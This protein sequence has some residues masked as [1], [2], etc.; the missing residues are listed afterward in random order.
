MKRAIFFGLCLLNIFLDAGLA[1]KGIWRTHARASE[2]TTVQ[3]VVAPEKIPLSK[4]VQDDD[5]APIPPPT[6]YATVYSI[7]PADFA[8]NLRR[9]GCPEETVKDILFAEI[10]RRYHAR[11]KQLRPKPADHV[12]FMWSPKT[13]EA[14]LIE[15]RQEAAEIAREKADA[16]R[17][18]L[19]YDVTV[20]MPLY[21]MTVSDQ[22]FQEELDA[23]PEKNRQAAHAAQEQY[24][25]M[26][27]QL[28]SRTHGFW[29]PEDVQELNQLKQQRREML[30]NLKGGGQQ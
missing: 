28:R 8:A 15:R 12:P 19:G 23:I 3:A 26:V 5:S 17:A 4:K 27:E 13:S 18:A 20:P 7:R 9:V 30:D 25:L 1:R 10:S 22:R 21:A 6:P 11:E 24:W 2:I 14:K 16:L 29:E